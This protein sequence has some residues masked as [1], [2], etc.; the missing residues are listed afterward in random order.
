[1]SNRLADKLH[2]L[3]P[4]IEA[5]LRTHFPQSQVQGADLLHECM[6]YATFSGGRRMRPT[7]CLLAADA[8]GLDRADALPLAAAVEY[9]HTASLIYDDLPA[10]DDAT[11]RRGMPTAHGR[12]GEGVALLG[13]LSLVTHAFHLLARWPALVQMAAESVGHR[14]MSAGQA[15]DLAGGRRDR[16]HYLKTTA[17]FRVALVSPAVAVSADAATQEALGQFADHLGTAYQLMDDADDEYAD[18]LRADARSHL[19]HALDAVQSADR[20]GLLSGYAAHLLAP[21]MAR[22]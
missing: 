18:N 5:A 15:I 9:L 22:E 19:A 21:V 17:L 2:E 6:R 14:G 7:L 20:D 4:A 12:F 1:M 13:G 3:A 16:P 11:R 10:M 8:C